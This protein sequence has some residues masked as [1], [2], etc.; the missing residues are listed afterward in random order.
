MEDHPFRNL[1]GF[2]KQ[3]NLSDELIEKY[4]FRSGGLRF[5]E[6]QTIVT[7]T[8]PPKKE[9]YNR[10]GYIPFSSPKN[11]WWQQIDKIKNTQLYINSSSAANVNERI[12]NAMAKIDFLKLERIGLVDIFTKV[13]RKKELSALDTDL[14]PRE[15][16]FESDM[17]EAIVKSSVKQFLFVYKWAYNLFE[18]EIRRKLG[19]VSTVIWP[20]KQEGVLLEVKIVIIKDKQI[21]LTYYPMHGRNLDCNRLPALNKA[22][23]F[24]PLIYRI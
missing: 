5:D 4:A 6:S 18:L 19:V 20:Y 14:I 13:D 11:K 9:Y 3:L 15:T 22:L 2:K 21:F 17:F 8:F 7:G 23:N 12:E 10:K 16:I 1:D 24:D